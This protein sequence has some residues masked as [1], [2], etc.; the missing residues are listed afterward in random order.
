[1]NQKNQKPAKVNYGTPLIRWRAPEYANRDRGPVW[2]GVM[3]VIVI[4]L[5]AYGILT[6]SVPFALVIV[7]LVAVF[8]LTHKNN[9]GK[10][11]VAL[12]DMGVRF[13]ERF[14]PYDDIRAFWIY[15]DPPEVKTLNLSV[16]K[17]AIR[18]VSIQLEEENPAEIRALLSSEVKELK[19]KSESLTEILIRILKL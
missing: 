16:S 1:M 19:N 13:G 2:K 7:L 11:E 15:F 18:E 4:S 9:P 3:S 10:V 14:Y 6:D 17:G 8:M 5:I 12:T